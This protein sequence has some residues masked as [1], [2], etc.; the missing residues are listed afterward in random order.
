MRFYGTENGMQKGNEKKNAQIGQL[1]L[2]LVL[3]CFEK[4]TMCVSGDCVCFFYFVA[5]SRLFFSLYFC[6]LSSTRATIR[7]TVLFRWMHKQSQIL[8]MYA[9]KNTFYYQYDQYFSY[10]LVS[11]I[12]LFCIKFI[13]FVIKF[14]AICDGWV[15]IVVNYAF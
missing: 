14:E 10:K 4:L 11:L 3:F 12:Y 7:A 13:Y 1:Y 9:N 2:F 5:L 15:E 8:C 6:C